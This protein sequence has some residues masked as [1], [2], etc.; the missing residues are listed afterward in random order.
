MLDWCWCWRWSSNTLACHGRIIRLTAWSMHWLWEVEKRQ[1]QLAHGDQKQHGEEQVIF[2]SSN[3]Y[4]LSYFKGFCFFTQPIV[5]FEWNEIKPIWW[6]IGCVL[7][8]FLLQFDLMS[9]NNLEARPGHTCRI[10]HVWAASANV[11]RKLTT[12]PG[13]WLVA[14]QPQNSS[15]NCAGGTVLMRVHGYF[16][17]SSQNTVAWYP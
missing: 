15:F 7:R 2:F 10:K 8:R 13:T 17:N 6:L 12:M 3:H 4:L 1:K 11:S 5:A 9:G 16:E 14:W